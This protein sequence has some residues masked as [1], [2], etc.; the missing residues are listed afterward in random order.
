MNTVAITTAVKHAPVHYFR[1]INGSAPR[2][3]GRLSDPVSGG[4]T[5]AVSCSKCCLRGVCLPGGLSADATS[6]VDRLTRLKRKIA[7]GSTLYRT[8]DALESLHAIR[9]GAFKSV[10]ISRNGLEKVTGLHLPGEVIGLE[11]ISTGEIAMCI[12]YRHGF[13]NH[14]SSVLRGRDDSNPS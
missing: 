12:S 4:N 10:G 7:R 13:Q 2:S 8:G 9:S 3:P 6:Q 5:A 11:A 14:L 1:T